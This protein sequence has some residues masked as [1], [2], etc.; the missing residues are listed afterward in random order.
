MNPP[1]LTLPA[2]PSIPNAGVLE[3]S[4][5]EDLVLPPIDKITG[6]QQMLEMAALETWRRVI[7]YH[8]HQ[9]LQE[10][11]ERDKPGGHSGD[12]ERLTEITGMSRRG[13]RRRASVSDDQAE[14]ERRRK[15]PTRTTGEHP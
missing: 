15:P 8:W 10:L 4:L 9:R 7:A 13:V 1:L 3:L 5:P 6:D 12:K 14:K 2:L 11:W